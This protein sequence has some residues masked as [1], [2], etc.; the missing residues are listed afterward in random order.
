VSCASYD[1]DW[2]VELARRVITLEAQELLKMQE[3]LGDEIYHAVEILYNCKGRVVVTGMG[4]SGIIARK[5]AATLASTGTPSLFLHPA[6][7]IHG[8]LGMVMR[9][10]AVVALSNSGET[11]EVINLLPSIK[12]LGIPLISLTGNKD[13]TLAKRS[14]VVLDTGVSQEACPLGI[15]PTASTTSAL[16]MGD[17]L[18][19]V[20][21]ERRGFKKEDF[22]LFHPGGAL[23]KR[24]LL[25]VEDLMHQGDEI[26]RVGLSTPLKEAII[27]ISSKRLGIT[28]VLG[29]NGVVQGVITDGDLRRIIEREG[30]RM[31]RLTAGQVMTRNPKTITKDAL[32]AKALNIMERHSITALVVV[33]SALRPVGLLHMHDI[34]KAGVV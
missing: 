29:E 1:C 25:T 10:D 3:R 19:V 28:T 6:E 14:D 30:E 9:E 34:L 18:A 26:P 7:G 24:L 21:L 33:D 23:G 32:A 17:A 31:F 2:H 5:I 20:L 12:R 15:V 27:E 16:A 8:D 4:K 22:A 13:S 11:P